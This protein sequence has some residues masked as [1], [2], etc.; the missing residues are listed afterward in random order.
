MGKLVIKPLKLSKPAAVK[1]QRIRR[2]DGKIAT[3]HKLDA[4]S[5]TFASD[6]SSVFEKNVAKA[7][8]KAREA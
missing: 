7:R 8:R 6:L 1:V 2:A 5:P 3:I 4:E